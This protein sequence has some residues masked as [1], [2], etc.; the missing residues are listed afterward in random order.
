MPPRNYWN[1]RIKGGL[2]TSKISTVTGT[3]MVKPVKI[4]IREAIYG[5]DASTT[6]RG[7]RVTE[8]VH[9]TDARGSIKH[10][11]R[12]CISERLW[13]NVNWRY[14]W[15]GA[16][17]VETILRPCSKALLITKS[18]PIVTLSISE[19]YVEAFLL[20]CIVLEGVWVP[21]RNRDFS[22]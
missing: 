7:I 5:R 14:I 6:T 19:L 11:I 15:P 8:K 1:Y 3:G 9:R 10:V 17:C 20:V 16:H 12:R 22:M 4:D 13:S 18:N 2:H 21:L